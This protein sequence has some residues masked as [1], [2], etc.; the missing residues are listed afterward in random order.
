MLPTD[1]GDPTVA[2]D[3]VEPVDVEEPLAVRPT[4]ES[5]RSRRRVSALRIALLVALGV[6]AGFVAGVQLQKDQVDASA[7]TTSGI[8]GFASRGGSTGRT[9]AA[10]GATGTGTSG[11]GGGGAGATVGQVKLIDGTN[12]YVTDSSGNTVKVATTGSTISKSAPGT[13]TDLAIGDTV[14]VRGTTGSDGTVAA[15]AITDSGA[16]GGFAGGFGGGRGGGRGAG[17]G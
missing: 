16:G 1:H 4:V 17:G 10:G 2:V 13:V 3:E 14:I 6:G 12:V 15:T 9:G 5:R 11:G 8:S 7:S